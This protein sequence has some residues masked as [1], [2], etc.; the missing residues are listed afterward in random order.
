MKE[1]QTMQI[2]KRKRNQVQTACVGCKAAHA[3]CDHYRPCQRCSRLEIEDQCRDAP[4]KN[5][6]RKRTTKSGAEPSRKRRKLS[7]KLDAPK[8]KTS[9][10]NHRNCTD[11]INLEDDTFLPMP[12]L[13]SGEYYISKPNQYSAGF[14]SEE[15]N[16]FLAELCSPSNETTKKPPT[17]SGVT[18]KTDASN[19]QSYSCFGNFGLW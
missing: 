6:T 11:T 15:W 7:P 17:E 5:A 19:Q 16:T 3:K 8:P 18:G 1:F 12:K 4:R 2:R 13:N 10:K 14:D 9:P